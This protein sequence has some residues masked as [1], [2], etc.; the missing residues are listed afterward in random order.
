MLARRITTLR[1][2]M[3]LTETLATTRLH[4]VA[5]RTDARTA[6]MIV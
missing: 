4:S 6:F 5:G 3:T 1:P 2:A